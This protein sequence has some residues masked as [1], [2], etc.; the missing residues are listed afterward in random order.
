MNDTPE[1]DGFYELLEGKCLPLDARYY[2]MRMHAR[3][4]ELELHEQCRLLGMSAERECDLRGKIERL[5]RELEQ[6]KQQQQ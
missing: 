2:H 3:K 4:I 6:L 1:T 5:E